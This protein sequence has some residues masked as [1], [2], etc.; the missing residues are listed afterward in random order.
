MTP[1]QK[2]LAGQRDHERRQPSLVMMSPG[3]RRS[4]AH[5]QRPQGSRPT[6]A[7]CGRGRR[8]GWLHGAGDDAADRPDIADRQVD[9]AQEQDEDLGHARTMKTALWSNRLTRLPGER[10][11]WF[12]LTI[13]KTTTTATSARD[14]RQDAGVAA[15][16]RSNQPRRYSPRDWA[17]SSGGMTR[18]RPR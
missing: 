11:T 13:S 9:L 3:W 16:A 4:G 18:P 6:T 15:L 17:T 1:N 10:K 2:H 14:D 5:E 12:G 7:S 8:P